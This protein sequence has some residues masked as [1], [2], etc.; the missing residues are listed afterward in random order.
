MKPLVKLISLLLAGTLVAACETAQP[1]KTVGSK[2]TIRYGVS[3]NEIN[4]AAVR[5]G[6]TVDIT[7]DPR[8]GSFRHI[9]TRAEEKTGELLPHVFMVKVLRIDDK[10]KRIDF[11]YWRKFGRKHGGVVQAYTGVEFNDGVAEWLNEAYQ[12]QAHRLIWRGAGK[13]DLENKAFD[14]PGNPKGSVALRR[15]F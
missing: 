12:N 2:S 7:K 4:G 8:L 15:V 14:T 3:A 5:Y 10:K 9:G 1:L 6:A 13:W 11:E